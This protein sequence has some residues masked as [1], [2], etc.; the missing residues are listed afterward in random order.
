M[1]KRTRTV[2]TRRWEVRRLH[3]EDHMSVAELAS[4][5]NVSAATI[6]NDLKWTREN[7]DRKPQQPSVPITTDTDASTGTTANT[8]DPVDNA[9]T[10]TTADPVRTDNDADTVR[11]V[12]TVHDDDNASTVHTSAH[13]DTGNSVDDV[14]NGR[15]VDTGVHAHIDTDADTVDSVRTGT[16]V[17][18]GHTVGT[19]THVDTVDSVGTGV[20]A[21]GASDAGRGSWYE[22]SYRAGRYTGDVV[23]GRTY[24]RDEWDG[25]AH[26]KAYDEYVRHV[27]RER[28][29]RNV[30][31]GAAVVVFTI[32][33]MAL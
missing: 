23:H 13:A 12:D 2:I 9:P 30:I 7:E 24:S 25:L 19:G 6:Y 27:K 21:G 18:N 14:D 20:Q 15:T 28:V 29:R 3:D 32:V 31:V 11:T 33:L 22:K 26:D 5:Y 4:K 1:N 10:G 8:D 17:D 16:H